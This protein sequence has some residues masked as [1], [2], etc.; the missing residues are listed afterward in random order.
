MKVC[1]ICGKLFACQP[2]FWPYR[3]GNYYLCRENCMI[4]FDV[5]EF[6]E[7]SGW[8]ED[9]YRRKKQMKKVTLEQKKK[10]VEIAIGGGDPLKFLE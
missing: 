3:R 2:E 8:C 7:K 9:Y 6:R 10:A 1:P 5:R 4:V